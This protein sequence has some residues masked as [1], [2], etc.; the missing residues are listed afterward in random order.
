M[1]RIK[2]WKERRKLT[3]VV[4]KVEPS[5]CGVCLGIT[6]EKEKEVVEEE[7]KQPQSSKFSW[8]FDELGFNRKNKI[9]FPA[10]SHRKSF[11]YSLEIPICIS[12]IYLHQAVSA[13]HHLP[14]GFPMTVISPGVGLKDPKRPGGRFLPSSMISIW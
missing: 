11:W 13:P 6:K 10:S 12:Y 14:G 3:G 7:C 2:R 8:A 9:P 1:S 4:S 5:P